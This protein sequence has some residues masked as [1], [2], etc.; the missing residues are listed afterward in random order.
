MSLIKIAF[1]LIILS[2]CH[3]ILSPIVILEVAQWLIYGDS[4]NFPE[5]KIVLE[6]HLIAIFQFSSELLF[7]ASI[8]SSLFEDIPSWLNSSLKFILFLIWLYLTVFITIF[9]YGCYDTFLEW[10]SDLRKKWKL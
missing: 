6:K 8:M 5:F 10:I 9:A 7:G 3:Y 1:F 4:L 2:L